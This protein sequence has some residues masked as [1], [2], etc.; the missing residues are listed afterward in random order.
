[1]DSC[2]DKKAKFVEI[3]KLSEIILLTYFYTMFKT[4]TFRTTLMCVITKSS[5]RQG[6]H[7]DKTIKFC[8]EQ[9][10]V[11]VIHWMSCSHYWQCRVKVKG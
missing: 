1:M 9:T 3:R 7:N 6:R 5:H 10:L 4:K 8:K 11:L 2:D